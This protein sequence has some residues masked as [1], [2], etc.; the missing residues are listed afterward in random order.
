MV[1]HLSG[2][3]AAVLGPAVQVGAAEPGH[4]NVTPASRAG[5][6]GFFKVRIKEVG[7][8]R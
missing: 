4:A 7:R 5:D 3:P 8:H 1:D 6:A 2:R